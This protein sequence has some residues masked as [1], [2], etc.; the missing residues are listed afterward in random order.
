MSF[1]MK[2]LDKFLT[3]QKK[4]RKGAPW[5]LFVKYRIGTITTQMKLFHDYSE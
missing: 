5:R 1:M 3:Y 4:I 2:K